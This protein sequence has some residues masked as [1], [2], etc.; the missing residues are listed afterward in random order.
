[1]DQNRKKKEIAANYK[2]YWTEE[3][4]RKF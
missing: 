4:E 3:V 2:G 1:M